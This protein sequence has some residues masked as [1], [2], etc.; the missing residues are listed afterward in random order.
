MQAAPGGINDYLC[1]LY[2]LENVRP[3]EIICEEND[4]KYGLCRVGELPNGMKLRDFAKLVTIL[5]GKYNVR[6][7]LIG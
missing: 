4:V 7:A 6:L 5:T 1:D 3:F 2:G